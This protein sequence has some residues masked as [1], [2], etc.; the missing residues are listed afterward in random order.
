MGNTT[1][2]PEETRDDVIPPTDVPA[3]TTETMKSAPAAWGGCT[4]LIHLL[5]DRLKKELEKIPPCDQVTDLNSHIILKWAGLVS[6]F[7]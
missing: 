1:S 5:K 2:I 3:A 7:S 4:A 6:R